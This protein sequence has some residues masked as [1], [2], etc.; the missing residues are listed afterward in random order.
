VLGGRLARQCNIPL[1][2][3]GSGASDRAQ[4]RVVRF[5]GSL[6]L[7][8]AAGVVVSGG[9]DEGLRR[10]PP[11]SD[12]QA[13]RCQMRFCAFFGRRWFAPAPG[14]AATGVGGYLRTSLVGIEYKDNISRWS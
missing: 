6:R 11:G 5:W 14:S 1:T 8:K 4:E 2:G 7:S 10:A 12:W 13:R 9:K 3:D